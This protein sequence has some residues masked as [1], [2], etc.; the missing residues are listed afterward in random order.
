MP[1]EY[2]DS[3]DSKSVSRKEGFIRPPIPD[4]VKIYK[5][6]EESMKIINKGPQTKLVAEN[7]IKT[8]KEASDEYV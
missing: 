7:L 2:K 4:D 3:P 1:L 5:I 6:S 8:K